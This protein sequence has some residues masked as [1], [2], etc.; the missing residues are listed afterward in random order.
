[1]YA[2]APFKPGSRSAI[3]MVCAV[4]SILYWAWVGPV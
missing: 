3:W 1:M 2:A 4:A